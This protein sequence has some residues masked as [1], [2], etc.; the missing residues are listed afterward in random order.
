MSRAIR[1]LLGLIIFAALVAAAVYFADR[2][3]QVDIVW[4]GWQVGTSVGVLVAAAVLA[5]LGITLLLWIMS[6]MFSLPLALMR[7]RRE[8]R[9]RAGYRALTRGM[10]ALPPATRERPN[11]MPAGPMLCSPI[12]L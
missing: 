3:G 5:G 8:R 4:Q 9:R 7:R 10:V 1:T 2:P 12:R 6:A 11:A